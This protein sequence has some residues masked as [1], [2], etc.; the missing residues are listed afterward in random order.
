[1]LLPFILVQG[2][3]GRAVFEQLNPLDVVRMGMG[4]GN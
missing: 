2:E 3:K 4:S 1:M